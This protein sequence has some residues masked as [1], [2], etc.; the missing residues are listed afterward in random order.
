M[1]S[2]PKI[3]LEEHFSVPVFSEYAKAFTQH[4]PPDDRRELLAR[5]DDFDEQRIADMD[6]GHVDYVILS[7]SAPGMQAEPDARLA[8][9]LATENNDFLAE[10]IAQHPRRFGGFAH[11]AMHDPAQA[12]RELERTVRDY[13]F[14][15]ALINGHTCGRYYDDRAYDEFWAR[16]EAL[17]APIYLHPANFAEVPALLQPVPVLQGATFGW[18]V[19]T[20]GH[21]LRLLFGGVFD[22]FPGL[23]LVLGHMGEFLPFMRW[24]F[25]SR[26]AAYPHGVTLRQP[27]SAYFRSN[28]YITT[29]GVCSAPTLLGAIGE[30]GADNVLFSVD[31]PYESTADAC[32]FIDA[33]PLDAA[34]RAQV[35]HGNARRLF[36][37]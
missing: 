36:K 3:A 18:S 28:I 13:G 32:A 9:R 25:D 26:F 11:L 2:T 30:M 23:K 35:C 22:R 16:A 5:L 21:A 4:L 7:Q 17:D 14:K 33:A 12:A 6:A 27:P 34:T 15:G 24:R 19:E 8:Q 37:L 31:Y 29:A 1:T 20:G 10:R